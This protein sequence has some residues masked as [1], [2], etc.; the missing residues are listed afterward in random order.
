MNA[1]RRP[2]NIVIFG[3][4]IT[5]SWGNGH[6]TTYRS[7][8]TGLMRRGHHVAFYERRRSWY[9]ANRDLGHNNLCDIVLYESLSELDERFPTGID[10]DLVMIG[11]FV[12]SPTLIQA[13]FVNHGQALM[14]GVVQ[15][16]RGRVMVDMFR[17]EV[18]GD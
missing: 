18:F 14:H 2:L 16:R 17:L 1:Y 13:F 11:S 15:R 3:L 9:A 6:A 4:S 10:A 7:L 8:I 5:S 12:P